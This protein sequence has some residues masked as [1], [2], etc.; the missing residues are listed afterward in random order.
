MNKK[1]KAIIITLMLTLGVSNTF[2]GSGHSHVASKSKIEKNAKKAL[3]RFVNNEKIV[4]SWL[5]AE[6]FNI[7][8]MGS[9][10]KVSF[11]NEKIQDKSKKILN[12]YMT[13]YGKVKG[14]NYDK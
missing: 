3:Q 8:K 7:K 11:N 6:M 2:A 5:N 4:K 9:E 13:S 12:F 1:I 10:W 14:A